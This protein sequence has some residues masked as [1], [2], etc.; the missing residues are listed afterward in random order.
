M[1]AVLAGALLALSVAA[2][3]DGSYLDVFGYVPPDEDFNPD[4]LTTRTDSIRARAA[5]CMW[6]RANLGI[7]GTEAAVDR[8]IPYVDYSSP[9]RPGRAEAAE[10]IRAMAALNKRV[11]LVEM[12]RHEFLD[13]THRRERTTFAD[14]TTVTVDWDTGTYVI[15]P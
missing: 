14:G 2:T 9:L 3:P 6:V 8:V 12:I 7:V 4:R 15:T 1:R 13:A 11:A 5:C 10:R